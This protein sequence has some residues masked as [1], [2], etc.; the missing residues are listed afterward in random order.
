[1]LSLG[2]FTT[3]PPRIQGEGDQYADDDDEQLTEGMPPFETSLSAE[4]L[5]LAE[6]E[7]DSIVRSSEIPW[8]SGRLP[9]PARSANGGND[10]NLAKDGA[11]R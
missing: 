7:S 9:D 5:D 10:G 6:E 11:R 8:G 1:M 4:N 3:V 2:Q